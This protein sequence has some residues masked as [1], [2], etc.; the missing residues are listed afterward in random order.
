MLAELRILKEAFVAIDY[1]TTEIL[2]GWTKHALGHTDH[3]LFEEILFVH[4]DE[5]LILGL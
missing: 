2:R 3:M 5:I 1:R 4:G